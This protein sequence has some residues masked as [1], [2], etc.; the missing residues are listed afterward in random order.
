MYP[1][2][3]IFHR[4]EEITYPAARLRGIAGECLR[5]AFVVK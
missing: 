2:K 4:N 1:I 5:G 3:E